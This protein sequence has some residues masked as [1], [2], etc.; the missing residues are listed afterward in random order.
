M[1][2]RTTEIKYEEVDDELRD[3]HH[4]EVSFPLRCD[5][6]RRFVRVMGNYPEFRATCSCVV[7]IVCGKFST[8][9]GSPISLTHHN[10]D[11]K[12]DGDNGP[13][14]NYKT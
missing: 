11:Q 6:K 8:V 5:G 3:L 1:G 4:C 9:S 10:M 14:L 7:V 12:V 2:A 13:R